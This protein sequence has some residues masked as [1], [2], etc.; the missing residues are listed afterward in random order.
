M[1]E[2]QDQKDREANIDV[3]L[4]IDII[5]ILGKDAL[6]ASKSQH[7]AEPNQAKGFDCTKIGAVL[8]T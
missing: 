5:A 6:N 8:T 3:L 7:L 2:K 1:D 4:H